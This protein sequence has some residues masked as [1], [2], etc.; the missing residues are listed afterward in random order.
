LGG[1]DEGFQ[2]VVEVRDLGVGDGVDEAVG[3]EY[4]KDLLDLLGL[5]AAGVVEECVAVVLG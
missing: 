4:G 3:D 1:C 2:G 5:V